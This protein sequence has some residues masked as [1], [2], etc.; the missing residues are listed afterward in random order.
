[1]NE[2]MQVRLVW[3]HAPGVERPFVKECRDKIF[4]VYQE[5]I[6]IGEKLFHSTNPLP[7][8]DIKKA[9]YYFTQLINAEKFINGYKPIAGVLRIADEFL[10]HP[11]VGL[12]DKQFDSLLFYFHQEQNDSDRAMMKAKALEIVGFER[13]YSIND[14]PVKKMARY[15]K[16]HFWSLDLAQITCSDYKIFYSIHDSPID[17]FNKLVKHIGLH[18]TLIRKNVYI[19]KKN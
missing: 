14:K 16:T 19:A 13:E 7:P 1:M 12:T 5:Y 17:M 15:L 10:A 18:P 2:P 4:N 8:A 3:T 9:A 6:E 11:S